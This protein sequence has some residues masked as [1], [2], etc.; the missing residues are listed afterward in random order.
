MSDKKYYVDIYDALQIV[1]Q[2]TSLDSDTEGELLLK[3]MDKAIS[4]VSKEE[5]DEQQ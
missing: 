4:F 2:Y 5:S 1:A 3:L